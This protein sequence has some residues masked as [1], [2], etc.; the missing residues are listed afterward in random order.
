MIIRLAITIIAILGFC[1]SVQADVTELG[2]A[3]LKNLQ[4]QGVTIIDVRR[5]DEWKAT[6]IIEGS[7]PLTFFDKQGRYDVQAWLDQV[8]QWVSKDEPVVLIC[9][10]GV[11][12]SKIAEFLDK[13]VGFTQVHNVTKGISQ[14]ISADESVVKWQQ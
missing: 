8:G 4:A 9:A 3:E 1:S 6:G 7:H 11:R 14:W 10:H 2:N 12:S 5:A 13:R